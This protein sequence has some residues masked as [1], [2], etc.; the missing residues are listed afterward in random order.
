MYQ[1]GTGHCFRFSCTGSCL[2]TSQR[3]AKRTAIWSR[4]KAVARRCSFRIVQTGSGA[5]GNPYVT[6]SW[7]NNFYA[8]VITLTART[9]GSTNYPLATIVNSNDPT[10]FNP[11][12][13]TLTASGPTMT[14]GTNGATDLGL[15][16]L[17][18]RGGSVRLILEARLRLRENVSESSADGAQSSRAR[19]LER[20]RALKRGH[21]PLEGT[22]LGEPAEVSFVGCDNSDAQS[23]G[24]HCDQCI[25][26]QSALSDQFVVILGCQASKYSANLSPVAEIRHQ[27]TLRLV[28]ISFQALHIPTVAV[29]RTSIKFFEHNC[30]EPKGRIH[31]DSAERQGCIVSSPQCGNVNGRVEKGGLHLTTQRAVYVLDVNATLDETL[32]GFKNQSVA[33]VFSN[34]QIQRTL[35]GL[36][37]GFCSQGFLGA[38]DLHGIQLEVL[39]R[40]TLCRSHGGA[41]SPISKRGYHLMYTYTSFM[42]IPDHRAWIAASRDRPPSCHIVAG[43]LKV[44]CVHW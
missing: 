33:L 43:V 16:R 9:T 44:I 31:G 19:I 42:Y 21:L 20:C 8:P 22:E 27:D 4:V 17:L 2:S 12:S 3:A 35:D 38:L 34:R 15:N 28:K 13:Y 18:L 39:V 36:S 23:P 40:T 25:I 32:T 6:A 26:G 10:D 24:A 7:N 29:G 11:P 30:T 41:P 5:A 1:L 37:L 14:G